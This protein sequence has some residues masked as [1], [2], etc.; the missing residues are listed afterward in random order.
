MD[1][2]YC[3]ACRHFSPP[4]SAGSVFDSQCGF[5]NWKK[6]T[7]RGGGFSVHAKSERHKDSMIAWRDYQRAVKA[8][9]T[10]ANI[11]DKEHSKKVKENREYIRTIGEVILLTAR[12]NIA[13]RGHNESEE[14]NNKGNFREILE[15]VANHD[16]AVK[17]R[18]TSI[19]NAKF[20][21][22]VIQN[23]VLDCLAEMVRSEI[24]EEVK[25]SQY[26]SIMADETKDV[27]K[28]EQI[29]FILRYYYDGAIKES[30]LHFESAERLD[31]VGLTEKIVNLLEHHGLDYKNHLIGQAYDGAAVMSGK[32]SGVQAKIKETAPFAFYIHCSAHCLNLVLVDSIKAVPEAEE[33]FAL[34]QSLYVFTSGSYV[35]PKWLAVQN[36][37][38]GSTR[39]LQ[40]LSDTRWACRFIALRNIMDRLP[41]LKRVLQETAQERRG[42]KSS[43]ARGLLAQ[44]DLEFVVHLVTLRTLFGETK[45]LS[46]MLQSSTVDL[47]K[48]ADLVEGLVQTLTDFRQESFFDKLWGEVLNICE[49]CDAATQS[50]A[51]RQI[52]T[53]SRLREY[54]ILSSVGQR[55]LASDKE[56]YRSSFFY[57]VIDCMLSEL[58]RRFSK[59]SCELMSSIRSLHPKSD[60]FL[61]DT[62][63]FEFGHLFDANIEDLG[64]ELHQFKRLLDRKIKTGVVE[65]LSD[66]VELIRFTEP[67][68]EVFYEFFRLCKI[69]VA[70]PV[71]SASCE[72]SFSTLKLVKTYLRS[73]T[74]DERLSNLGVLSIE[75]RRAKAL[76][77]EAFVDRFA[78]QHKRRILLL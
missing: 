11:L 69:A 40:K 35:H 46:D 71:S 63:L 3:H 5:R 21:S 37:M 30:F 29:S 60:A 62:T 22:K 33:F 13:Q 24:I 28:Q 16:P 72:R 58:S 48:A 38:Y 55:E 54:H 36:E 9:T 34:L 14:S 45:L 51:K 19:H 61:K 32:H 1:S 27:S 25:S 20:T 73:T 23:E 57:S 66:T 2:A 77:L 31:A 8:N 12:Q 59:T 74:T 7:E 52:K 70:L 67:Y 43:E 26:F 44:I 17:R 41:A 10:L 18:L 42:E 49:Q 65:K 78:R 6:A 68:K 50:E 64:H 47:S 4:S 76:N 53:S 75:S 56:T 15:M 39:E